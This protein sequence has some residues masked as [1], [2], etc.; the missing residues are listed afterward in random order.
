MAE[1][2]HTHIMKQP[3]ISCAYRERL[4]KEKTGEPYDHQGIDLPLSKGTPILAAADGKVT[5][6]YEELNGYGHYVVLEHKDKKQQT[7]YTLYAQMMNKSPLNVGQQITKNSIVGYVGNTGNATG[8]HVHFEIRLG[9]YTEKQTTNPAIYDLSQLNSIQVKTQ[10]NT[11]STQNTNTGT[12][13]TNKNDKT[14]NTGDKPAIDPICT[15]NA[16]TEEEFIVQIIGKDHPEGQRVI[17]IDGNNNLLAYNS[18]EKI[19][20]SSYILLSTLKKWDWE[21]I[22]SK[23]DNLKAYLEID[24][25]AGKPIRLLLSDQIKK[26]Q[27]ELD[28]QHNQ[29]TPIIPLTPLYSSNYISSPGDFEKEPYEPVHVREGWFYIFKNNKLWREININKD[30]TGY[31]YRDVILENYRKNGKYTEDKRKAE[32]VGLQEIWIQ[33]CWNKADITDNSFFYSEVQLSKERL[34][35][36]ETNNERGKH[37]SIQATANNFSRLERDLNI[38]I[39]HGQVTLL[40]AIALK[41]DTTT[42]MFNMVLENRRK[43]P[44]HAFPLSI[45][46]PQRYRSDTYELIFDHPHEYLLDLTGQYPKRCLRDGRVYVLRYTKN[47][48]VWPKVSDKESDPEIKS[49]LS[50]LYKTSKARRPR[51]QVALGIAFEET[52][53]PKRNEAAKK[54]NP[55]M[56]IASLQAKAEA[57]LKE[58]IQICNNSGAAQDILQDARGRKIVGVMVE[59]PLYR[60]RQLQCQLNAAQNTINLAAELASYQ[61]HHGSAVLVEN[62]IMPAT[63]NGSANGLSQSF[64]AVSDRVDK[65]AI[66]YATAAGIREQAKQAYNFALVHFL[67]EYKKETNHAV[68]ADL[69]SLNGF[70]YAGALYFISKL[71]TTLTIKASDPLSI[72]LKQGR[73]DSSAINLL[74]NTLDNE[75]HR[76]GTFIWKRT[77]QSDDLTKPYTDQPL[78]ENKG[79]GL[80]RPTELIRLQSLEDTKV[81]ADTQFLESKL[82]A[83]WSTKESSTRTGAKAVGAAVLEI[84]SKIVES[85]AAAQTAYHQ[86]RIAVAEA[87]GAL[88]T[89]RQAQSQ[90]H[91]QIDENQRGQQTNTNQQADI[92]NRQA[93]T[94]ADIEH[95]Q[96]Q[97]PTLENDRAQY[98]EI[99]E[100]ARQGAEEARVEANQRIYEARNTAR[101]ARQTAATTRAGMLGEARQAIMDLYERAGGQLRQVHPDFYPL[102]LERTGRVNITDYF[103]L[104]WDNLD[105]LRPQLLR[106]I[107]GRLT[108]PDGTTLAVTNLQEARTNGFTPAKSGQRL[109]MIPRN[110][111]TENLIIN[112]FVTEEAAAHAQRAANDVVTEGL[113]Q[114]N[115]WHL[116]AQE[117]DNEIANINRSLSDLNEREAYLQSERARYEQLH[118]QNQIDAETLQKNYQQLETE[119]A[120][121]NA[122]RTQL[123]A[124]HQTQLQA[125]DN[126]RQQL[127]ASNRLSSRTAVIPALVLALETYNLFTET[128]NYSSTKDQK[129]TIRSRVIL[130]TAMLD[131]A[132]AADAL[133]ERI[134]NAQAGRVLAYYA[135]SS[136]YLAT[137]LGAESIIMKLLPSLTIRLSAQVISSGVFAVLSLLDFYDAGRAGNPAA[138]GYLLIAAGST[139]SLVSGVMAAMAA[140]G[141][142][143]SATFLGLGPAGWVALLLIIAG[144]T[145]VVYFNPNDI[146]LWLINGP[147]GLPATGTIDKMGEWFK[148]DTAYDY[149]KDVQQAYYFLLSL[150]SNGKV[151]VKPNELQQQAKDKIALLNS[152]GNTVEQGLQNIADANVQVEVSS[153]FAGLV[154]EQDLHQEIRAKFTQIDYQ[155]RLDP[156]VGSIKSDPKITVV[157]DNLS[158]LARE[159]TIT[160]TTYYYKIDKLSNEMLSGNIYK[161]DR[162]K[163]A[164]PVRVQLA[165]NTVSQTETKGTT[166]TENK[167][168]VESADK[169]KQPEITQYQWFFPAPTLAAERKPQPTNKEPKFIIGE[170]ED[171]WMRDPVQ[172]DTSVN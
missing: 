154:V 83:D 114:I 2:Y 15:P 97:R 124:N 7:V 86:S 48:H 148:S 121:L 120:A 117:A 8:Y 35:Y 45:A 66:S 135:T 6:V 49:I 128:S 144:A 73:Y 23:K 68:L 19:N 22:E 109:W 125:R 103:V 71:A 101:T 43:L 95:T 64:E 52:L 77:A 143:A 108:A 44:N 14:N 149:L 134:R 155:T 161:T 41:T 159:M 4:Q 153:G 60:M 145:W 163:Y 25:A 34:N 69:C 27:K 93:Q 54:A 1:F 74:L 81:M 88:T 10:A 62:I 79:D 140:G 99:S 24:T 157:A 67:R 57:N 171:Y 9:N 36:L 129:G 94:E 39:R 12:K 89:N 33:T 167:T 131:F 13:S 150:L 70:D 40:A 162:R 112:Y 91:K 38:N 106:N 98:G 75:K 61:T 110:A 3:K 84:Y 164:L 58:L 72:A 18:E 31:L 139:V 63:I 132:I 29:I 53:V 123:E 50:R 30:D 21:K 90:N 55:K 100:G 78:E 46:S 136:E 172:E 115:A 96:Q 17:L 16:C 126:A 160:G 146:Q 37:I 170:D 118:R 113:R 105:E 165:M 87:S 119:R 147:F 85:V 82:L 80:C 156:Y 169:N 152:Q 5:K 42:T 158:F 111:N 102:I 47:K 92:E 26:T 151:V 142:E 138:W 133:A 28:K 168:S 76:L 11:S 59:D 137:K 141:A 166:N 116:L 51:S 20:S 130:G 56:D 32:G 65:E 122:E 107:N 127:G 104:L